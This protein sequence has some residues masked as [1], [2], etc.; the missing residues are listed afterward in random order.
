MKSMTHLFKGEMSVMMM[1]LQYL[2]V[3]DISGGRRVIAADGEIVK[4]SGKVGDGDK[5][6]ELA[7]EVINE[8]DCS[9]SVSG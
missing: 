7:D 5:S 9:L 8:R 3:I 2:E 4:K 1:A 6:Q